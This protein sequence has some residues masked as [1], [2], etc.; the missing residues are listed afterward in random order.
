MENSSPLHLR[1]QCKTSIF[2]FFCSLLSPLLFMCVTGFVLEF[3]QTR[4]RFSSYSNNNPSHTHVHTQTHTHTYTHHS[5]AQFCPEI[6]SEV[7]EMLNNWKRL[8]TNSCTNR[9][10]IKTESIYFINTHSWNAHP[11]LMKNKTQVSANVQFE[12]PNSYQFAGQKVITVT[13]CN[14]LFLTEI[15]FFNIFSYWI[16]NFTTWCN[17]M[18]VKRVVNTISTKTLIEDL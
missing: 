17:N 2:L 4:P 8:T 6:T 14:Y 16:F 1:Q 9:H 12:G 18:E 15:K 7:S 10:G 13:S 5:H 3:C 11:D